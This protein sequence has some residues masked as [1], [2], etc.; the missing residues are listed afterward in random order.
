[1]GRRSEV[2]SSGVVVSGRR[3]LHACLTR[4]P[5]SHTMRHNEPM[6]SSPRN[7]RSLAE[8]IRVQAPCGVEIFL[9]VMEGKWSPL[10]V[11]ELLHGPRR[12]T[13]L[14]SGL[15]G[16]SAKTLTDRL[17]AFQRH[18]LVAR[19]AF[20]EIPPKVIYELTEL[21]MTLK[22]VLYTMADWGVAHEKDL[23]KTT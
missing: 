17:R 10:I 4:N 12:F 19:E 23:F 9:S 6:P 5:F 11:R 8:D 14:Q 21:G 22:P 2:G 15:K 1:M 7:N 18:G 13:E 16:V 3:L 20:P